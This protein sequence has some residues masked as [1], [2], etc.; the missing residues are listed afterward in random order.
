MPYCKTINLQA[1][2]NIAD[3]IQGEKIT[4]LVTLSTHESNIRL[5]QHNKY[6]IPVKTKSVRRLPYCGT[7]PGISVKQL[8][9]ILQLIIKGFTVNIEQIC[10]FSF[11]ELNTFKCCQYLVIFG[12]LHCIL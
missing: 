12:P 7:F 3:F 8:F 9:H 11:I 4:H 5:P 10:C 6:G 1:C 2:Y